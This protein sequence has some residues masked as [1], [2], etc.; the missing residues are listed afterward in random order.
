M[1]DITDSQ[2]IEEELRK[3]EER[4]QL[5]LEG[6]ELG[7]WDWNIANNSIY[8]SPQWKKMLGYE[9]NEIEDSVSFWERLLHPE[10]LPRAW[11]SVGA[12]LDGETPI[13]AEEFRMRTRSGE[14]IWTAHYGKVVSR[15]EQGQ[16][17]RM[18][19]THKNITKRKQAEAELLQAK[20]KAEVANQAKSQFLA[21]MSHE[22]RTPLNGIL[23]YAQILQHSPHLSTE[24]LKGIDIINRSG[25]H[26]LNLIND[27]LDLAKIEAGKMELA[28][29]TFHLLT[30]LQ[31]IV[32]ICRIRAERKDLLFCFQSTS[33][34]PKYVW[35][36]EKRLRQILVNLLGNAIKFSH[37]GTV[38][39]TVEILQ[40]QESTQSISLG[41]C[42]QEKRI[43]IR[44]QVADSGIGISPEQVEKI[45]LPFEQLGEAS[46]R[47]QGTG[48][49]LTIS[50]K[51]LKEMGSSL[52]VKSQPNVGS[53]FWFDLE[54]PKVKGNLGNTIIPPK[55]IVG[56]KG[57]ARKVLIVD[58]HW[59]NRQIFTHL[60]TPLGFEIKEATN[61]K[62]GL[63]KA[64]NFRPDLVITDL[65]MPE[66]NGWQF[67]Q[68]LRESPSL[69]SVVA[70]ASSTR[71]FEENRQ[72]CLQAGADDFL[73]KPVELESMLE[74]F[75]VH[76]RL[77][78][79]YQQKIA[80]SAPSFDHTQFFIPPPKA[81]LT[82]L[83]HLA[84]TGLVHDILNQIKMIE[85][86]DQ[87]YLPFIQHLRQLAENFQIKQIKELIEK[88][89]DS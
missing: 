53:T 55:K 24:E 42:V 4:L 71:V 13:Y 9:E 47:A 75:R 85:Q 82:N 45:F 34:L 48:L 44:F 17:L 27:V 25:K 16:P 12:H 52:Q 31:E 5:A 40:E 51:L 36:D 88:Y 8:L 29:K 33:E 89:L 43:K 18:V 66:M 62:E 70:I 10:D 50:Q 6:S 38:K 26:L 46:Q 83:H 74:M 22:L 41:C 28:C 15:D 20:E 65:I 77:E 37:W 39:F 79:I 68:N 58:D 23:G 59:E 80:F 72:Q 54:L 73:P 21:N 49:G 86:T 78:W 30:F 56:Y 32:G 81:D 76:L 69:H 3:S 67:L 84:K 57:K 14:W 87:K 61:G 63:D 1:A 35:G 2:Y 7:L 19:G 64:I 11:D 60:L